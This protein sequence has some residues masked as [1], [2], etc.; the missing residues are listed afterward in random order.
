MFIGLMFFVFV[1]VFDFLGGP[2]P[3]KLKSEAIK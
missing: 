3:E 2:V 1:F